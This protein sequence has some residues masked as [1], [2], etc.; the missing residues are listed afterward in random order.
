[1]HEKIFKLQGNVEVLCDGKELPG[2]KLYRI[3]A[4]QEGTLAKTY[5]VLYAME[6]DKTARVYLRDN[7]QRISE[8]ATLEKEEDGKR[9]YSRPALPVATSSAQMSEMLSRMQAALVVWQEGALLHKVF[10]SELA[11]SAEPHDM[12]AALQ[13]AR[14]RCQA[15]VADAVPGEFSTSTV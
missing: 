1:M 11:A 15:L 14:D 6:D 4:S 8:N 5:H 13:R 10:C 12:E 3:C 7:L 9:W 2:G